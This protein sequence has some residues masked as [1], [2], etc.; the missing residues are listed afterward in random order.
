VQTIAAL[1]ETFVWGIYDR[2]PLARWTVGRVAL[3]GDAAHPMVPHLGQGAGQAIE[4]A[5]TLGVVLKG[6]SAADLARRLEAYEQL[7]RPRTSL[8]QGVARQAGQFYR[9]AYHDAGQ[10]AAA[11]GSWAREVRGILEYD[12]VAAAAAVAL[13]LQARRWI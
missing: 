6:A 2:P 5:Y 4:D 3:L 12:A 10:Q 7:R 11:M 1:A 9:S 8:V 13:R